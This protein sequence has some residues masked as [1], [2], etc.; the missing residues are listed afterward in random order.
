MHTGRK[1]KLNSFVHFPEVLEMAQFLR[2]PSSDD[3]TFHLTG[4]LMHVGAE[5]NHGHY[6]AH[7]Q[8]TTNGQWFKFSDAH[9]E[10]LQGRNT[11]LGSEIDLMANGSSFPMPMWRSCKDETPD[12][13]L[14]SIQCPMAVPIPMLDVSMGKSMGPNAWSMV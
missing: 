7:I 14:K 10:K 1:K 6:I 13:A 12:L 9:V 5:A 3:N 8:E 2:Q 11:R 4:V